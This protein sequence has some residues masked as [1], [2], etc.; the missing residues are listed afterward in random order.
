M[1]HAI[2]PMLFFQ[3]GF[4]RSIV[5][6]QR[7]VAI[8]I[9]NTIIMCSLVCKASSP[10]VS[11]DEDDKLQHECHGGMPRRNAK[12]EKEVRCFQFLFAFICFFPKKASRAK[13]PFIHFLCLFGV[14]VSFVAL[15]VSCFKSVS[16]S[17]FC[18]AKI[19]LLQ[20][21]PYKIFGFMR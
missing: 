8:I 17:S 7:K 13:S 5:R 1:W 19:D 10:I 15:Q 9:T 16:F 4:W 6:Q 14:Y 3:M 2:P 21:I 12:A 18:N 20:T 11:L